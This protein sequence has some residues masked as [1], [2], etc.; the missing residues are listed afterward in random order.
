LGN[1][2]KLTFSTDQYGLSNVDVLSTDHFVDRLISEGVVDRRQIYTLGHG[3][4]G[5]MAAMYA[6]NRPDRVAAFATVASDASQWS[7]SCEGPP[8]PAFIAYRACDTVAQCSA[9]ERWIEMRQAAGATT[10]TRRLS[11]NGQGAAN[12]STRRR[13]CKKDVGLLN[14]LRWPKSTENAAL[15]FLSRYRMDVE[16]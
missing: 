11:A 9:V 5:S 7:W 3:S 13:R 2:A 1:T 4:G 10:E 6:M 12:C 15:E 8:P 16:P 14:H